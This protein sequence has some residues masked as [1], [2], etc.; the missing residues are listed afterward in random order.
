MSQHPKK[1]PF[2][3]MRTRTLKTMFEMRTE[4]KT[5]IAM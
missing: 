1:I 3:N 2:K 4:A 5:K